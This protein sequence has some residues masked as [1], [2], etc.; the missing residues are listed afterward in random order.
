MYDLSV[1]TDALRRILIEAL[2]ASPL[3]GFSVG[4]SGQH[5]Q[6]PPTGNDCDLNLFLFHIAENKFLK[7]SFWNQASLTDRPAGGTRHQPVSYEPLCLDLRFLVSAQSQGSY[8]QEQQVMSVALRALHDHATIRLT[9][10]T[11]TGQA[12]S[13]MTVGMEAPSWD[14][15]S[16][17]WQ[18]LGGPLRMT[19]QYRVSVALLTPDRQAE[20]QPPVTGWQ[21]VADPA[22]PSS[23]PRL[24]GT[25]RRVT[26]RTQDGSPREFDRTPATAGPGQPVT[27]HGRGL[28]DDDAVYLVTP[29]DD[30]SETETELDATW[31]VPHPA[32]PPAGAGV[33][34]FLL[35]PPATCPPPGRYGL[36]VGR[37]GA[38]DGRTPAVPLL[39]APWLDP[40]G[41]PLVEPAGG[42]YTLRALNV[43]AGA[44][45]LLGRTVLER[46]GSAPAPGQWQLDGAALTLRAPA[47][48]P[49]G[50]YPVRL[51]AAGVEADPGLW[52]VQP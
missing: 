50:R 39:I 44:E 49:Q 9:A 31:K 38:R 8:V 42:L 7:N 19:A 45:V 2:Q 13:E 46:V 36:R 35:R 29:Q 51:R 43:P 21:L 10:P 48:L 12:V 22:D 32:S 4:V 47:G 17:L 1:V 34:P 24:D 37:Q 5:P 11:A 23:Q 52:A 6:Q 30:G 25:S 41:G 3:T 14:E 16:R 15:L 28:A 33:A 20:Q 40:A 18:A 27:L 26:Y